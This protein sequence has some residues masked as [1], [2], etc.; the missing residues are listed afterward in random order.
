M[1][2]FDK[3][4]SK[5]KKKHRYK[6]DCKRCGKLKDCYGR[7]SKICVDCIE[8]RHSLWKEYGRK[9]GSEI[10]NAISKCDNCLCWHKFCNAE[11]CR[12][13]RWKVRT[14]QKKGNIL[15]MEINDLDMLRYY[16]LHGCEIIGNQAIVR[17]NKFKQDGEHIIIYKKCRAL[18]NNLCSFHNKKSQPK[19]CKYPNKEKSDKKGVFL[20]R[21]C[22]FKSKVFK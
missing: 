18:K 21:N 5:Y 22:L 10:Y 2:N 20:T 9:K 4:P 1:L 8:E 17:L 6:R 13:F 16:K 7:N 15:A 14:P 3:K 12:Q 11:C 19:I